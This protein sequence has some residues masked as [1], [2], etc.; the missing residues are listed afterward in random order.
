[1]MSHD[2]LRGMQKEGDW[3][4]VCSVLAQSWAHS[5]VVSST[6]LTAMLLDTYPNLRLLSFFLAESLTSQA[7]A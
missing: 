6:P 1:M 5:C 2:L 4:N 7:R 3:L